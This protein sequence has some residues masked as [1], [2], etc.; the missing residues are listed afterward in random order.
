M[1]VHGENPKNTSLKTLFPKNSPET[2]HRGVLGGVSV[3]ITLWRLEFNYLGAHVGEEHGAGG[4]REVLG[5]VYDPD[6]L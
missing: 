3:C 4:A 6:F 5:E 1:K 2:L